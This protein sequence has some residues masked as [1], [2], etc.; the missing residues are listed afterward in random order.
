MP[1]IRTVTTLKRKREQ[2]SASIKLY[3][4]QLA[5]ARSDLAHISAAIRIFDASG[6]TQDIARYVDAYRL[7][8]RGEPWAVCSAALAKQG[9]LDTR[10]LAMALM[11]AKGMDTADTV[12]A[13]GLTNRLI[14]SLRMQE[15]RG[16]V[17]REGKRKGVTVWRLP[18]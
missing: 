9:P 4:R 6:P 17:R 15:K 18:T 14:H 3:E 11:R 10:E 5:Q 7:F 13:K 12:L 2:I 16:R 1:E 8:K